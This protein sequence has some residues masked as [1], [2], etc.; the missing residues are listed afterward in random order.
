MNLITAANRRVARPV[1]AR[2]R[3]PRWPLHSATL[4]FSRGRPGPDPAHEKHRKHRKNRRKETTSGSVITRRS[5][6]RISTR[7]SLSRNSATS[8]K[9]SPACR[10]APSA[11]PT[12]PPMAWSMSTE[13]VHRLRLLH[14]GLPLR[15]AVFPPGAPDR[16]EMP[17][18][19]H[20]I[21][22][23]SAGL[24]RSLP[25]RGRSHKARISR[26]ALPFCRSTLSQAYHDSR[27]ISSHGRFI[28]C[29]CF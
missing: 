13:L 19:L 2:W 26:M 14:H 21:S 10:S 25:R 15:G 18:L 23:S 11:R 1:A 6:R 20:L 5:G 7:P 28:A 24:S 8:A 12:Q 16:R 9:I 29:H 4:A 3:P 27:V 22:G 17:P